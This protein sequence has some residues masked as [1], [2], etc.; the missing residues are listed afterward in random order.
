M[1]NGGLRRGSG[2]SAELPTEVKEVLTLLVMS[3]WP[4]SNVKGVPV[5]RDMGSVSLAF[6]R[7]VTAR[8]SARF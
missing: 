5:T 2:V 6:E 7:C 4:I 1:A 3:R 8:F